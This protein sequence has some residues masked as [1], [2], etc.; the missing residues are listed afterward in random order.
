MQS[1]VRR[2][3]KS[4]GATPSIGYRAPKELRYLHPSGFREVLVLNA[5][6][7]EGIDSNKQAV[8][9]AHVVGKKKRQEILK[10]AEEMKIRVLNP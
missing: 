5:K 8:R 1:K 6:G 9:I 7:L 2:H 10:K 4:K 3:E